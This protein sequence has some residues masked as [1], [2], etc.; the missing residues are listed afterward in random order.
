VTDAET[1][2]EN[3][4]QKLGSDA[5]ILEREVADLKLELDEQDIILAG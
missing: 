4:R 1:Q 3:F 5:E 2:F